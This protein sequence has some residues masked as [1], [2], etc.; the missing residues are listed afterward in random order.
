MGPQ[1]GAGP[2]RVGRWAGPQS[3]DRAPRGATGAAVVDGVL[4][5][6]PQSLV[7]DE[8]CSLRSALEASLELRGLCHVADNALQQYVRSRPAPSPESIKRAK[9]LDLAGLGLHPVFSESPCRAGAAG[10][11]AEPSLG[12]TPPLPPPGSRF[13]EKELQRLRLVDSLKKYRSRAVSEAGG[14]RN[15]EATMV[16]DSD[17]VPEPQR[18]PSRHFRLSLQHLSLH[19]RL[20]QHL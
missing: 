20:C 5:R 12:F 17:S 9:E 16:R 7:D 3:S 14:D 13:E 1:G 2:G 18:D 15:T 11:P 6:V 4:G 8:D 10:G 19:V